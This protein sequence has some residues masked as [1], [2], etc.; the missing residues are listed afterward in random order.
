[1]KFR[2]GITAK[3]TLFFVFFAAILLAGVGLLAYTSGRSALESAAGSELLSTALEKEAALNN[4]V[5]DKRLNIAVLASSPDLQTHVS[6]F[7][8]NPNQTTHDHLVQ[9]LQTWA[10][11]E[12]QYLNLAVIEAQTGQ[13]VAATNPNEEGK[14]REDRPFFIEGK[15][16][17]YIQN[18]YYS[19]SLQ[20][21]AMVAAAPLHATDGRLLGVLAG[22]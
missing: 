7:M 11:P 20:R 22:G 17:P 8:A 14:F 16:G 13:I 21:P 1:M 10:G 15:K 5:E 2:P 18:L 4:W 9:S 12:Q 3:L 19:L 6:A